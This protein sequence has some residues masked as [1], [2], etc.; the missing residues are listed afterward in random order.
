MIYENEYAYFIRKPAWIPS[1]RGEKP[2]LLDQLEEWSHW[3][4]GWPDDHWLGHDSVR[5]HIRAKMEELHITPVLNTESVCHFLL[6]TFSRQEEYGLLNRLD[7]PTSWF[8]YF[9]KTRSIYQEH[10]AMQLD[11]RIKK[12]YIAQVHG[13]MRYHFKQGLDNVH[14]IDY[15]MM[16]HVHLDDRMVA[17]AHESHRSAWKWTELDSISRV[18]LL[19]YHDDLD[20][21]I[22]HV[23]IHQWRRHQIRTHTAGNW[24]PIVGDELY[25]K[26]HHGD[27]LHLWSIGCELL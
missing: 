9:A 23:I 7:T 16:H 20:H 8:L 11:N 12:H 15:P 10:K 13:D 21:S 22:V 17:I 27:Q 1:T 18:F 6:H 4:N 14:V 26:K 5:D 2:C 19:D 24:Y 25:G 3:F